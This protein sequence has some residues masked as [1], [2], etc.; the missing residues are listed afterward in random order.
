MNDLKPDEVINLTDRL[1]TTLKQVKPRAEFVADLKRKLIRE[2]RTDQ[3]VQSEWKQTLTWIAVG[4]GSVIYI[5]TLLFVSAKSAWWILSAV[6]ALL[7]WRKSQPQPAKQTAESITKD[8]EGFN[9][10]QGLLIL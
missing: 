6:G 4:A 5:A 2:S 9:N 10:L 1:Q 3:Q 8:L 7:G